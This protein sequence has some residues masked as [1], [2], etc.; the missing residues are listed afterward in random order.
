[1]L[2]NKVTK[3]NFKTSDSFAIKEQCPYLVYS[4]INLNTYAE[5]V[6]TSKTSVF[7]KNRYHIM[8]FTMDRDF[9]LL[10]SKIT[11]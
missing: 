5:T 2:S 4:L 1:M 7:N 3:F 10:T 6:S 11:T 8:C 9:V